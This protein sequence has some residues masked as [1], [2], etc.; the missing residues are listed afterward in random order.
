MDVIGV[1]PARYSSTRFEGKVLVDIAG[2]PMLQHVWERAKES[3]LL[4]ELVIATDDERIM[5]A[6]SEFGAK[7]VMTARGHASGTDRIVE[8]VNPIDVKVIINIQGDEPLVHPTMIDSVARTL[9]ADTSLHM[10]TIIRKID[11]EEEL[12]DPNVVK[13]VTDKNNFALYFS[14][15][16]IPYRGHSQEVKSITYYKHIGLYGYTKD[17]LFTYRNLPASSLEK[18]ERLEQ[19]RVLENGYRIKVVETKFDTISV[20]TP[21]DIAKIAEYLKRGKP[22]A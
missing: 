22:D 20:D 7:A 14:R 11:N 15:A 18:I 21:E 17:F 5:R 2:K 19:L 13:V 10:A 9:L 1:I 12:R 3:S 16:T 6:V 4:D 8:V